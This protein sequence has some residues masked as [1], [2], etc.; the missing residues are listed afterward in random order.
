MRAIIRNEHKH[1]PV[2]TTNGASQEWTTSFGTVKLPLYGHC[3]SSQL[4]VVG[5]TWAAA[6]CWAAAAHMLAAAVA[7]PLAR[8]CPLLPLPPRRR[9]PAGRPP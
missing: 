3:N 7:G 2:A 4:G 1:T 6:L 5:I 9:L 8:R